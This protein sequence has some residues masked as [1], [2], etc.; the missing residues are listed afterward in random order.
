MNR[1]TTLQAIL[2]TIV[3]TPNIIGKTGKVYYQPPENL[4]MQFPCIE[5]HLS[6]IDSQQADDINYHSE[7]R[8]QLTIIDA[9]PESPWIEMLLDLPKCSFG[10]HFTS[11]GLNH[12]IFYIYY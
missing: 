2:D 7:R 4:R 9:S 12:D 5:Y 10:R 11:D 6:T 8:Y 3:L 1:R